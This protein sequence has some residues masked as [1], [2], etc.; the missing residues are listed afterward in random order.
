MTS[1]LSPRARILF[2]DGKSGKQAPFSNTTI[3]KLCTSVESICTYV[4][5]REICA[6]LRAVLLI[7]QA[8]AIWGTST[9]YDVPSTVSCRSKKCFYSEKLETISCEYDRSSG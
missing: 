1:A 9:W 4:S 3:T 5:G 2:E 7:Q 6:E 8:F